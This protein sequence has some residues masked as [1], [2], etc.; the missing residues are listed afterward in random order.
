MLTCKDVSELSDEWRDGTLPF[1]TKASIGLHLA[2][3]KH[4]RR[5]LNYL[6]VTIS[7]ANHINKTHTSADKIE[8]VMKR[9]DEEASKQG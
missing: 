1:K 6:D 8:Q 9:I 2:I 5:Y 7:A 4:C 3:C